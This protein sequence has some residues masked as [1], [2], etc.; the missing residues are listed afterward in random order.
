MA[1]DQLHTPIITVD[2]V[3]LTESIDLIEVRIDMGLQV[4]TRVEMRFLDP[5]YEHAGESKFKLG[6]KIVIKWN[7]VTMATVEITGVS[8]QQL[9]GENP[10]FVVI[11]HDVS[12]RMSRGTRI[13]TYQKMKYSQIVQQVVSGNGISVQA[14]D[15]KQQ[16]E[17]TMQ[18]DSDLAFVTE[19][20]NRV[21]FDW[22]VDPEETFH[23]A[24]PTSSS[25]LS[26]EDGQLLSFSVKVTGHHPNTVQVV[27]WD[28]LQ[29]QPVKSVAQK[30]D[31]SDVWATSP[32]AQKANGNP[33]GSK[34]LV[35]ANLA[36]ETIAEANALSESL[37]TKWASSAVIAKGLSEGHAKLRPGVSITVADFGPLDGT[38]H[39]T[40]VEHVFNGGGFTTRF[41]AG[42][43]S[44]STLV[45][46]LAKSHDVLKQTIEHP[47][48]AVGVVTNINDPDTKNRVRLKF[49]GLS[50]EE[51]SAWARV[52]SLGGGAKRG[53][54]FIPEVGDEVL[55]GFENGDLRQPVVI[56]GL[57]SDKSVVPAWDIE[58]GKVSTRRIASRRGHYLEFADGD[59]P[60]KQHM[61]MMLEGDKH[62]LRLGA[63][64]FDIELPQGK[65]MTI[66][67]GNS[68]IDIADNGD[69]TLEARNIFIK[70][71]L[72]VGI[73]ANAIDIKGKS[74]TNVTANR[75][76]AISAAQVGIDAKAMATIKGTAGVQ[77]N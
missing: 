31:E 49:P 36:A 76:V 4:P 14:N 21:G 67:I 74:Q 7:G 1:D 10:E 40:E 23:F 42:D 5:H 37:Q 47:S 57:Y 58:N 48:L 53:M 2:G 38:Y 35:S 20:A 33:F 17:Y 52:A 28:H 25:P 63:D 24:A 41:T 50:G 15:S 72:N 56:G 59:S 18:V 69:M 16:L 55:V 26:F 39:V 3:E 60:A 73:E 22:W 29:Q 19:L 65:P 54:V 61:L 12:H 34:T 70:A 44:P 30:V 13:A 51:E 11:A 68:K 45:D 71:Q 62:R 75:E 9:P 8:V 64:R 6:T 77:I 66:K 46:V 43:R 27:G 32:M